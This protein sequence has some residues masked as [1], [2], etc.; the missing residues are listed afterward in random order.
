MV[1]R[2]TLHDRRPSPVLSEECLNLAYDVPRAVTNTSLRALPECPSGAAY[3][4]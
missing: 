2:L 3:V 1:L 4:A